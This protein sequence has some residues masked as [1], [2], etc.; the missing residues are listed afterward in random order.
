VTLEHDDDGGGPLEG[1]G[2][3]WAAEVLGLPVEDVAAMVE[4]QRRLA[5]ELLALPDP[6]ADLLAQ[7]GPDPLAVELAALPGWPSREDLAAWEAADA[8]LAR[9]LAAA[10]DQDELAEVLALDDDQDPPNPDP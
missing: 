8:E 2:L 3:A 10:L 4:D 6:T 5:A 9:E 7:L 1:A